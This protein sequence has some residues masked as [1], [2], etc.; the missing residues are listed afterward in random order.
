MF[1]LI[2]V[3][4]GIVGF[5]LMLICLP[6]AL[7]AFVF[8][9]WMLVDSIRNNRNSPLARVLW[10]AAVWFLPLVGSVLYF[11]FGRNRHLRPGVTPAAS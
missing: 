3:A 7:G 9:A 11:F 2:D 5:L 8:W 4:V 6:F 1:A 10:A